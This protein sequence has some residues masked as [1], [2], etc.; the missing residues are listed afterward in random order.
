MGMLGEAD[1]HAGQIE[2]LCGLYR[3][4]GLVF[5]APDLTHVLVRP[6]AH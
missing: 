2:V 1:Y 5:D 3:P 6:Q 4:M